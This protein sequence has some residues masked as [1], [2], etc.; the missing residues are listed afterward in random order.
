MADHDHFSILTQK[1]KGHAHAETKITIDW[2]G[3]TEEQLRI[4]ARRCLVYQFQLAV[5]RDFIPGV[6]DATTIV[7]RDH[8]VDR[9]PVIEVVFAPKVKKVT[10]MPEDTIEDMIARLSDEERKLLFAEM[11]NA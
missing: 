5:Q 10:A 1:A 2:T 8:A 7:A 6:P 9:T 4:L 11:S 3:I